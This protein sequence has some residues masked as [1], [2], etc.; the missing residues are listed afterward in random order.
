MKTQRLRYLILGADLIWAV[1]ALGLAHLLRYGGGAR[2]LEQSS[3]VVS[4]PLLLL[5]LFLWS[6]LSWRLRLDGFRGGWRVPA[7]LSQLFPA[8]LGLMA[9]LFAG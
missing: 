8:V 7:V 4:G 5:A 9:M 2:G 3:I 6:V 1:A